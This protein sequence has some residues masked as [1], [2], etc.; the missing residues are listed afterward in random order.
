MIKVQVSCEEC[1]GRVH[2]CLFWNKMHV[3]VTYPCVIK[4]HKQDEVT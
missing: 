1:V 2:S 3:K 4:H